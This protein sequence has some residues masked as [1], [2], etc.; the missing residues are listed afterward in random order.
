LPLTIPSLIYPVFESAL[1]GGRELTIDTPPTAF[2]GIPCGALQ[3]DQHVNWLGDENLRG[4]NVKT[5]SLVQSNYWAEVTVPASPAYADTLP[6]PAFSMLGDYTTTGTAASPNS[7]LNGAVAAGATSI[8]VTSGTGFLANQWVQVDIGTLAEVV[9]IQSV[10]SNTL[11]LT[12]GTPTR[13][14]HLTGVAITNT[15]ANY[16]HT[17]S[18]I[19]PNSSTG[20]T[21]AQPPTYTF[22]HRNLVAG[23]GNHNSDQYSYSRFTDLKLTGTKDGW[24]TWDGKFTSY[25]RNY[26]STDYTPSFTSVPAFPTWQAALSL[27][28]GQVYNVSEF[29]ITINRELDI[30]TT[31]DGSQNPYVIAAGPLTAMFGID[32]DAV[33]DETALGYVLN[34]TQP[35]L[36]IVFTNGLSSPNT[37]SITINAQLAGHKDAPLSAMKTLWGFKTTGELVANTTNV[38]NSGGYGPLQMVFVNSV[39]SFLQVS[40][41][42]SARAAASRSVS[43]LVSAL[44]AASSAALRSTSTAPVIVNSM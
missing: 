10:S 25:L 20:N 23:S 44:S 16:T 21:S 30:V 4:S 22:L 38:G 9:K 17:F 43:S 28:S 42:T 32:Y 29:S 34:N 19:N 33:S 31:A 7:T 13:F 26:P 40:A 12:T 36:S 15:T 8:T 3:T 6:I 39:P 2:T 5:Y 37:E 27:A 24:F 35:T 11:T 1:L 14:S 41:A 18:A